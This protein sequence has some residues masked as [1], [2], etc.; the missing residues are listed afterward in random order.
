MK[1]QAGV[2]VDVRDK[3]FKVKEE[4]YSHDK[5]NA[6]IELQLDGVG[7]EKII[8][9]FHFKKTNRFLEVAGVVEGNIA[10]VP[11]DTSL[12]TTD[13][14]VYGY[15]YAEKVVQSADIL[16]FSFWVR[17]S[18]IDKHS[19][20]PI[21]EKDTK[22]I[23][24]LTDIVTKAELEEAIKNVHVEGATF[25]DSE[26]LRRLQVLETKPE[27]DTSSFATKQEL[28][29]KVERA[30]IEQIS[31]EIEALKTKT[32]K[33]TVYDDSAL[34]E[35]VT[36]L[37]NKTD[38]DTVY[39]DT[40]I[41]QRLEVL[42]HKPSVNT[43]ELVTKQELESKGYLTEHQSLEEYAKKTELPQP[44]NDTVLKMRVQTLETQAETLATKDELKAV[45]LKSGER[46]ERGE[47]G[48]QGPQGERG[49]DGLQG[50]QGLQGIQGERGQDGQTGPKG[51]RGE[52][53][54]AGPQGPIGLTGPK[55]ADGVG[56]PQKLT[57]NGNTLIL[58][59]G[60]GS[61]TL[62]ETSQNASTSSSELIGTGMPNGKVEGKLGQT[63]VDTAKTNGALKWIKRTPSGNTGW[64]V[65]D[66]DTGWKT[67]NTA[68]KLGNSYVKARRI[69][70]IV[71]LQ[72]GGLQW[73]WFGIV[74]RG[75]LGFVAHPGNREKKVFILANGQMPY[76][77]RTATSLIGPIYNDDGVPYGT[78]Y[79]G[80]YGDANHLRF[81]F[82]D[83]IPADK[84]IGD[85]RVSNISY[86]TDDP[87][88]TT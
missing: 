34:R 29:N 47:P 18:E 69:N 21:I 53:G 78:W 41:K 1:R 8:V 37:E 3:V 26:I 5:N 55:G 45:Q 4:F 87:W 70:D 74:R 36:A 7:A 52:Q 31:S 38:N 58:S 56:I 20:L 81:Q 82:L 42:E 16:K 59:D 68:S 83:P 10:T 23:V 44:Y 24:A 86:F 85:I 67:L 73:G 33:D 32:D 30:E 66:G 28:S 51:E 6:F 48:P 9:L 65:L 60:G 61:V 50:P 35:R 2:C 39:N 76:G 62:P 49:A 71:Q 77:Y 79:L 15:V 57:L 63:Y 25:D 27:I 17:L 72:F 54:P 13:E 88:P 84:D 19:E 75:G 22:R 64:A 11:F 46:G 80:G 12:I 14:I 40:E 43:S